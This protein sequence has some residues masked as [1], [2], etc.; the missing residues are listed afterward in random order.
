[1]QKVNSFAIVTTL[2]CGWLFNMAKD[3]NMYVASK[4]ISR[5]SKNSKA[6]EFLLEMFLS[7]SYW[8]FGHIHMTVQMLLE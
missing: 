7:Y 1:M 3:I 2:L 8:L 5:F 4:Y 6:F